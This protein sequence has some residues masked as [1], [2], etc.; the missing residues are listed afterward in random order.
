MLCAPSDLFVPSAARHDAEARQRARRFVAFALAMLIWVPV[1]G[2]VYLWLNAPISAC[3]VLTAGVLLVAD[4]V[5]FR[6][7]NRAWLCG[8]VLVGLAWGTYAAL[9]YTSGG[10]QAPALTWYA[11]VPVLAVTVIGARAGVFWSLASAASVLVF[12]AM[13]ER[14][15]ELVNEL[16]PGGERALACLS[17][18][19]LLTCLHV[20]TL[21]FVRLEQASRRSLAE[22]LTA[23][24]AADRAKGEFLANMSHEI[25]TPMTAILG[26]AELLERGELEGAA[27][28]EALHTVRRNGEHLLTIINDILDL[29]KIEAGK[30][31]L[32]LQPCSPADLLQEVAQLMRPRAEAK[33]LRLVAPNTALPPILTDVTRLR[34]ILINLVGNAIKFTERGAVSLTAHSVE[35]EGLVPQLV[36]AVADTGIGIAA[37]HLPGLFEPFRQADSS[38]TRRFGGTG[39]GLAISRRLAESLGGTLAVSS[40]PGIGTTF[41]LTIAAPQVVPAED[42]SGPP[43]ALDILDLAEAP[44][45][46]ADRPSS[47]PLRGAR[48]LLAEDSPDNQRLLGYLLRKAGAEVTLAEHGGRACELALSA[49]H[50]GRPF[51]VVL[52]DMQM[53][54]LDGYRAARELRRNGYRLPIVALTAH[55]LKSDRQKCLDA[56]CDD[57]VTKPVRSSQLI[58]VIARHV[59]RQDREAT[60]PRRE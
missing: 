38:M 50:S 52:M 19:G 49:A 36:L 32:E 21:V 54:V 34:Q 39:L 30:L 22:A 17:L 51:D 25:R 13:H 57:Y 28:A 4:L 8:Q 33:G 35:S 45:P 1:Y 26:Y 44:D 42:P 3:T 41:T 48:L 43:D 37:E 15:V 20:L 55:S 23:A 24:R 46:P 12:F 27:A 7:T 56:G 2:G 18:L 5:A 11:T 10:Y 40:S 47:A 60:G 6:C 53:P 31:L 14:G 29:S 16:S 58:A 9:S 59:P